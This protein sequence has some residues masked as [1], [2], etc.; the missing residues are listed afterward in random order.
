MNKNKD[1]SEGA[2]LDELDHLRKEAALI[3]G[4]LAA[5]VQKSLLPKAAPVIWI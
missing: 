4:R 3:K 5:E 2:L 1:G